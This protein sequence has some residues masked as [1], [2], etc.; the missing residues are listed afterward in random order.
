MERISPDNQKGTH[1]YN[2]S[3]DSKWAIHTF[4]SFN[5]PPV[6]GLVKLPDHTTM[7]QLIDN[8]DLKDKTVRLAIKPGEFFRVEIEDGVELDGWVIQPYKFDPE[9]KYPLLLYVY[10]GPAGQTVLD[11][12]SGS[13]Y[14]WHQML[15]QKG[16]IVMSIDNRGTP[17]PRG[18]EWRKILYKKLGVMDSD[19]QASALRNI[20]L[21]RPYIDPER[22]GLWGLERRRHNELVPDFQVS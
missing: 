7:T 10:G 4:S 8:S 2:I 17:A 18:R 6:T 15:A 22:I 9:K 13:R 21:K 20:L 11:R 1:S 14:L 12:W 3:P 5:K 16:Y 19:D